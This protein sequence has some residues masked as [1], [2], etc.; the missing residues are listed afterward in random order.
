MKIA[1]DFPFRKRLFPSHRP[2]L[3]L[4]F[5]NKCVRPPGSFDGIFKYYRSVLCEFIGE[6][7][8]GKVPVTDSCRNSRQAA[9][10]LQENCPASGRATLLI[11]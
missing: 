5:R 11:S 8:A 10:L 9:T 7:A 2:S 3:P 6:V 4:F 1:H